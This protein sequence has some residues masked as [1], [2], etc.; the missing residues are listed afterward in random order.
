MADAYNEGVGHGGIIVNMLNGSA[1]Q[2]VVIDPWNLDPETIK[3]KQPDQYGT[4]QKKGG[5]IIN[6]SATGEAQLPTVGGLGVAPLPL[7][8]GQ[9][10]LDPLSNYYFWIAKA[11]QAYQS[12]Q[13]WKQAIE[14][15]QKLN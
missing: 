14:C 13:F 15:E 6:L 12:G 3:L 10:F 5:R 8:A 7:V 2:G 11:G 4:S 9:Y 1:Q